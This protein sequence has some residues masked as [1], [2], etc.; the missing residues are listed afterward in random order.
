VVKSEPPPRR[1]RAPSPQDLAD[2]T[3]EE[4]KELKTVIE[5]KAMKGEPQP[6]GGGR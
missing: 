3:K 5:E 4:E 2:S 6:V 1:G